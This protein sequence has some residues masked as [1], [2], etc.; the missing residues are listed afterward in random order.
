MPL[1]H[2]QS[3]E[4]EK[5]FWTERDFAN[6][7]WHDVRI[8]AIAFDSEKFELLMDIDYM[9]AWADPAPGEKH[10]TFWMAPCTWV[11]SNVHSFSAEVE[12]G[13]GLQIDNVSREEAGRPKNAE[14]IVRE[15]EWR[16]VLSCQEGRF[17]F[18]SVGYRQFTRAKPVRA[19][20]QAFP[21]TERGG[22]CFDLIRYDNKISKQG[23]SA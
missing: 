12:W 22:V 14:S 1:A 19:R 11:F 15:Q 2:D 8:H 17:S 6:M 16:W 5:S 18:H 21:W 7:G 20:S 10:Y 13:L 23:G 9:F 3:Y 4:L